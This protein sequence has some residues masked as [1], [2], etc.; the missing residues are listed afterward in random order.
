MALGVRAGKNVSFLHAENLSEKRLSF[1]SHKQNIGLDWW[2][3]NR[4]FNGSWFII[5]AQV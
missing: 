4:N 3:G 1:D 2:Q 5:K